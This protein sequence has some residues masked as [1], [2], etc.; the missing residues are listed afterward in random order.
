MWHNWGSGNY[1][2]GL[3]GSQYQVR[4]NWAVDGNGKPL[5]GIDVGSCM[6]YFV[7]QKI[8]SDN[9]ANGL[10]WLGK[11]EAGWYVK[12]LSTDPSTM[13]SIPSTT[14][15]SLSPGIA[16]ATLGLLWGSENAPDRAWSQ[17]R[18]LGH[19]TILPT[20]NRSISSWKV[21]SQV[22]CLPCVFSEKGVNSW[23]NTNS[24]LTSLF[25]IVHSI[26]LSSIRVGGGSHSSHH[27]GNLPLNSYTYES[28]WVHM[29]S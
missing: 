10:E 17:T 3:R 21:P 19:I 27:P 15:S 14:E 25:D 16:H 20:G 12:R 4:R 11:P 24:Y 7:F 28:T 13:A 1:V 23:L 9:V 8:T 2:W 26:L 5:R 6:I 29:N 22:S 18:W